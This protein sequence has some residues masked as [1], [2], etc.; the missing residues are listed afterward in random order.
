MVSDSQSTSADPPPTAR[1]VIQNLIFSAAS[2]ERRKQADWKQIRD[3]AS[4]IDIFCLYDEIHV[5]GREV[6]A[7]DEFRAW[8][9]IRVVSI[10][11]RHACGLRHR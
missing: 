4:L 8:S 10:R 1:L 3:L 5:L 7:H 9:L 2:A 11:G 6:N